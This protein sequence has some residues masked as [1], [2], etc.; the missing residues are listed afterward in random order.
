MK[1][2]ILAAGEGKRLKPYTDSRPKCMVPLAGRPLL[3]WQLDVLRSAGIKDIVIVGGY[4]AEA[5]KACGASVVT[6]PRYDSTNMVG[7]LFCARA[8]HPPLPKHLCPYET[9]N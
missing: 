5:L 1:A 8:N 9:P 7:T 3:H 6:N 4:R 2:I